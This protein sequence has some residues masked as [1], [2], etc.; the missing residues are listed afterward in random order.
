M[1]Y[2]RSSTQDRVV[3]MSSLVPGTCF[4]T[5]FRRAIRPRSLEWSTRV[6]MRG[7][8]SARLTRVDRGPGEPAPRATP[9]GCRRPASRWGDA[10]MPVAGHAPGMNLEYVFLSGCPYACLRTVAVVFPSV[11]SSECVPL[12][13]RPRQSLFRRRPALDPLRELVVSAVV[14]GPGPDPPAFAC[15]RRT[16]ST[17]C[18]R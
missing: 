9:R 16:G 13:N 3:I 7:H 11:R 15:R 17:T 12:A 1:F 10:S 14:A 6:T 8:A 18:R 2:P 4:D 5:F